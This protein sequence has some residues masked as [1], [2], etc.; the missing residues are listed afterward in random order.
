M[1]RGITVNVNHNLGADAARLRVQTGIAQFR[2]SF[3]SKLSAC[4]EHWSGNHLDF[5]VGFM[6]Q[7]CEGTLDV[8]DSRVQLE[9]V[10]PGLLGF[11]ANKFQSVVRKKAQLLLSRQ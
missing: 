6:G 1:S 5:R 8:F 9:I 7:T 2:G 11:F 4:E 3:G 10:L